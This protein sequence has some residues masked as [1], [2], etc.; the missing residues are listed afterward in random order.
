MSFKLLA[1]RPMP[2]TDPKFLKN[3]KPGVIYKFYQEYEYL[4]SE[5]KDLSKW[6]YKSEGEGKDKKEYL[7]NYSDSAEKIELREK[8]P[9][10][11]VT[12]KKSD[13]Q[14]VPG[15][16]Y[17]IP[18]GPTINIS[19]V[20]GKNGSG[21]S[22]LLELLFKQV[23]NLSVKADKPLI[24]LRA[25]KAEIEPAIRKDIRT[26]ILEINRELQ[27]VES[28]F[29]KKDREKLFELIENKIISEQQYNDFD[30]ELD[31]LNFLIKELDVID[32]SK[33]EVFYE[34]G[35][36]H[37]ILKT[38]TI[39]K[40]FYNIVINYS[41]YA[42]NSNVVGGW[43][44]MIFHKNDSYLTPIVLN[45]MRTEGDID[46]NNENHL[47]KS[48]L[49][50]NLNL[51]SVFNK[52]VE[53][54][55]FEAKLGMLKLENN[56]QR[57]IL[58]NVYANLRF[59]SDG[60]TFLGYLLDQN[61][62]L[63][64]GQKVEDLNELITLKEFHK[65]LYDNFDGELIEFEVDKLRFIQIDDN[66]AFVDENNKET[67]KFFLLKYLLNKLMK[68]ARIFGLR[69][70]GDSFIRIK[71]L[72][73]V[74]D[75]IKKDSSHQ[76]FKIYQILHLLQKNNFQQFYK[77]A[78]Y[79][80][81]G[82]EEISL[83]I[84][85]QS[86]DEYLTKFTYLSFLPKEKRDNIYKVP[87]AFFG[88][89][90]KFENESD[91]AS[92]SSGELQM[93][94]SINTVIYHLRNIESKDDSYGRINIVLDEIELY[95]HVDYQRQYISKLIAAIKTMNLEKITD[96]NILMSTHSPFILSDIP[97]QN[98][99][100]LE[101][102]CPVLYNSKTFGA[103]IHNLL[104][105][106]FFLENG[107]QGEFAN[108]EIRKIYLELQ[109]LKISKGIEEVKKE[110]EISRNQE[111]KTSIEKEYRDVF[112]SELDTQT[113]KNNQNN[114]E[115]MIQL[116][117]EPILHNELK[118]L[119]YSIFGDEES[120]VKEVKRLMENLRIDKDQLQKYA[121]SK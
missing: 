60:K 88:L 17:S 2:G 35:N 28:S 84:T 67:L 25:K 101:H 119:Y 55:E 110:K 48:R 46:V 13:T 97:S 40:D 111:I 76:T 99:L 32:L 5:G 57:T 3:L 74:L 38:S 120:K 47:N 106:Q 66:D 51:L 77:S 117:G 68:Y 73:V 8:E 39:D 89:E 69:S 80:G 41:T 53:T 16:L 91:F 34:I 43:V 114:Y 108:K 21:K 87:G 102:G 81:R 37:K 10:L 103:N 63:K 71:N 12:V 42:L 70:D 115:Q 62:K 23:Y 64:N 49:L 121:E 96:V 54:M 1:I 59:K 4:N 20:V 14:K 118:S 104:K 92:L 100:R 79:L 36:K 11:D 33:I 75:K 6:E 78:N 26:R 94:N 56:T 45:P 83:K 7:V 58:D 31:K 105:N 107:F 109:F 72:Q 52:K 15:D 116:I 22:S 9:L 98:I 85:K 18:G 50:L 61:G 113:L 95:F 30:Q 93:I 112:K 19:A 29:L 90:F 24:N 82:Y 86:F 65:I 27:Q 44:E